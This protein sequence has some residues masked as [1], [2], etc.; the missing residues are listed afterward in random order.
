MFYDHL[1]AACDKRKVSISRVMS[2]LGRASGS[3]SAWKQG[4]TPTL[5][6]AMEIA[7][8]LHVSLDELC[9]GKEH[10]EQVHEGATILD[11]NQKDWLSIIAR[12][13][14]DK[15]DICKDFLRT[16]AV[17]PIKYF[18]EKEA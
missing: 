4:K 17:V 13:P 1:K 16:H 9:Y 5:E 11:E 6:I 3:S 8:Y 2:D 18:D 12:I 15:Q 10:F 14:K 7:E